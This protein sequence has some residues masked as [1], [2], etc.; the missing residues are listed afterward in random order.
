MVNYSF[1]I[2]NA[3]Q[4]YIQIK[5]TF[6]VS[7][8]TTIVRL[9]S[10]RPGRYELGNFAK[11][12]KGF[13][14]YNDE[15]KRIDAVKV[16]KDAWEIETT[17]TKTIRVEYAYYAFDLN[18]G[19]T[20]LSK[21]Q[22]YVN[23]VN[24]CVFTE[25]TA[26]EATKV[27]LHIPTSWK[28]AGSMKN[29]NNVLIAANF[30]ELADSPFICS[31]NLQHDS[32][33]AGETTFHLW[34]NGQ[35][36]PDWERLKKDF[37]AFSEKQIEKF[38]EFPVE[39]YHFLFQILPT[40]AYHGVEHCKSTVICLGPTYDLF[41]PIYKELLG[42]SSHELYHTWNVKAI[43]PIEMY[44]YDFTKEN[45]SRLGYICEGVTTYMGDLFLLKSNVFTLQQYLDEM[46]VQLQKHFDNHARFNYSVGD[47]S[48]DTWLDGYVP[49][50]P[51]R[52]VSIY[53]EGCLLAFV[54]DVMIMRA[55]G[56]HY[57][58]DAVMKKLY[59]DFALQG[60]GVSEADYIATLEN[61]SGISF[62][63]FF[64]LYVHGTNPYEAIL[65]ESFEYLGL[66]LKHVPAKAYSMGRL[67]FKAIPNGANFLVAALYPGGPADLA[68]FMVGDEL[69]AVNGYQFNGELEK[70]FTYF[71]DDQKTI[72]ISRGGRLI[73]TTIP[74][75]QRF[76]YSEYSV[77][78]IA[79]PNNLQKKALE[80]W[81]K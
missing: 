16:S 23:P 79:E 24:C 32:Y 5:A 6:E 44:P 70:W 77:V 56:N 27:E 58:L 42:V 31:A 41:G 68:G 67:G 29:E 50:A 30:D 73:E 1:S 25:E 36:K 80:H 39:E 71:T 61:I 64:E 3:S 21:E 60:K 49:G 17:S 45:Y 78:E 52:K 75:V 34:F 57:S 11:N 14:V 2:E 10:W 76:F 59:F 48:F 15:N 22:L 19:S 54:T 40:K 63:E 51:G 66:E 53:T 69:V 33:Q 55:T 13:K 9:P 46:N 74:E 8:E 35:V 65:T 62:K 47:S 28:V 4:Q 38:V 20:Y 43:R 26:Q 72:T 37:K 7:K 12:V 81:K 18:A